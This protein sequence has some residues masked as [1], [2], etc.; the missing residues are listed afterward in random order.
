MAAADT[1]ALDDAKYVALTT[2][3]RNG[4]AVVSPV[5]I[6]R[7]GD[8]WACTTGSDSGKVKRL[9]HTSRVELSPCDMKGGVAAGAPRFV[10]TGRVVTDPAEYAQVRKA[11]AKKYG[12]MSALLTVW[13]KVA[14]LFGSKAAEGAVAWTVEGPA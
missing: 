10:G 7:H 12:L 4:D 2:F 13:A 1:S 5:W 6:V 8:G 3:R 9:R 14:G 11:V